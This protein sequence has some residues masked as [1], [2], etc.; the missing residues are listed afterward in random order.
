MIGAIIMEIMETI[1]YWICMGQDI[2]SEAGTY[3]II[4]D[5]TDEMEPKY[6]IVRL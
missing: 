1:K 5:L 3:D 2:K 4:L 6:S